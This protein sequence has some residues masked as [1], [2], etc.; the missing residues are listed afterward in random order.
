MRLWLILAVALSLA[1][2]LGSR[3]ERFKKPTPRVEERMRSVPERPLGCKSVI[4]HAK[5]WLGTPYLYGGNTKRGVDCSGF[6][7]KVY[8]SA[9]N[10]S[11]PRT[12]AQMYQKGTFVRKEWLKC[13]DLVFFKNVRGRGVDH[14]GIYIGDGQFIHASSSRGVVISQLNSS[15]YLARFV[16]AK[17]YRASS[18]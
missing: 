17:N 14:V 4:K 2:C 5:A 9:H 1:S 16:A 11:L 7:K 15:Y 8:H 18:L 10:L 13:G 12:T 6:V 3:P